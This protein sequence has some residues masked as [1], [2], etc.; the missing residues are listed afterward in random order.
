M[1]LST[2]FHAQAQSYH[3]LNLTLAVRSP[4]SSPAT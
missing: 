2:Q 3:W 4:N 1:W